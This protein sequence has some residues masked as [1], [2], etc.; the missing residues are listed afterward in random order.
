MS[1]LRTDALW[2]AARGR[3][4]EAEIRAI[5]EAVPEDDGHTGIVAALAA[6]DRVMGDEVAE[7]PARIR[8]FPRELDF[9]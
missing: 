2:L 6:V 4:M 3:S 1:S 9:Q 5:L 8:E 7:F